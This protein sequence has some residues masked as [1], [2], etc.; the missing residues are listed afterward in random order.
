MHE[1]D[2]A[3]NPENQPISSS[4]RSHC[5]YRLETLKTTLT[6]SENVYS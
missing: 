6:H 5:R 3:S 2:S 4:R 1:I